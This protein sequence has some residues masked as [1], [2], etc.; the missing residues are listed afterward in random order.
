MQ[1]IYLWLFLCILPF[2]LVA[3]NLSS[4][5]VT[6]AVKQQQQKDKK[7]EPKW[8]EKRIEQRD[9][10]DIYYPHNAHME[11]MDQE[12]DS[13]MLCHSFNVINEVDKNVIE[14]ITTI[15]NEPLETIC[16]DCHVTDL[17][18]PWRCQLCHPDPSA[19]WPDDHNF[20]YIK[21]HSEDARNDEQVCKTCHLDVAFCT[22]CH[23]RRDTSGKDYHPMGYQSRHGIDARMMA[24][25]CAR[26]HNGFFCDDC[27]RNKR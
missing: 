17:R 19:I 21:H 3:E 1:I 12:G 11:V 5:S 6:D 26:C 16:H 20:G 7:K 24:S 27:H 4:D 14:S 13:C 15:A 9:R 8:W 10:A 18:G 25:N 22:D 2:G 23:F